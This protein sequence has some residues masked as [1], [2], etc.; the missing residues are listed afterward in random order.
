MVPSCMVFSATANNGGSRHKR[1][2]R[3]GI[4]EYEIFIA[5]S[6]FYDDFRRY[7]FNLLDGNMKYPAII[8][9]LDINKYHRGPGISRSSLVAFKRSPL[10]YWHEHINPDYVRPKA[11]EEMI[12]GNAVHSFI[13]EQD[14]FYERYRV[15]EKKNAAAKLAS[16]I[17]SLRLWRRLAR[18]E[19]Y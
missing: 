18:I 12:F 1:L 9:D 11:T 13:L 7:C 16:N 14:K 3:H 17:M 2:S 19:S 15:Y 5:L 10:H 4:P 6:F 8:H